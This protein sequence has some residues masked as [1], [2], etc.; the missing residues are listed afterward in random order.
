[1]T[2]KMRSGHLIN[3]AFN[4]EDAVIGNFDPQD[5]ITTRNVSIGKYINAVKLVVNK[6]IDTVIGHRLETYGPPNDSFDQIA[7]MWQAYLDRRTTGDL[8][9]CD[10]ANMMILMKVSRN[11]VNRTTD[12]HVD[13]IGYAAISEALAYGELND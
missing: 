12:N 2:D 5:S 1:M 4:I 13:I 9:V 7:R 10:V 3:A 11:A 8:T 6:A